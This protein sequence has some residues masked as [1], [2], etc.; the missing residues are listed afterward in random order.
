M[1]WGGIFEC[2]WYRG[3][4]GCAV[5][6]KRVEGLNWKSDALQR[7]LNGVIVEHSGAAVPKGIGIAGE[8]CGTEY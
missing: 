1:H 4:V 7:Y 6:P 3:C 2:L 8:G 5:R